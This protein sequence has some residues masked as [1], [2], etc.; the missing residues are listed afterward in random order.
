[1]NYR[2]HFQTKVTPQSQPIPGRKM[3]ANNAGG[4]V[5][6]PNDWSLLDRFLIL[7]T[8]GGS[9]YVGEKELTIQNAQIAQK[10][11]SLDGSRVVKRLVEISEAGRAPKNDQ[12]LFVLAMAAGLGNKETKKLALESLSKVARTGTHLF[13]FLE[14]VEGFRGWGRGLR[15]AVGKWYTEKN[16]D[17]LAYQLIKYQQRGGWSHRDALRLAHPKNEN[18]DALFKWVVSGELQV[19]KVPTLISAKT[20]ADKATTEKE[21]VNLINDTKL[22]WEAIPTQWLGSKEVWK[23]LL[24][25]LPLTALIRNL[26]RMTANET[27][28]PLSESLE[29]VREKLGNQEWLKKARV[30][31]MSLLVALKTYEQGH[32]EKGKLSWQPLHQIVDALDNAFYLSFGNVEPTNKRILFAI[33]ASGSMDS[34]V[35]GAT[36]ITCRQASV[37]LTLVN[38]AIEPNYHCVAF[39]EG[40]HIVDLPISKKQR[41]TDAMRL[42]ERTIRPQGTDCSLPILY[43]LQKN[44]KVDAFVILTDS[45]SWAGQVHVVQAL[46]QYRNKINPQARLIVQAMVANHCS[47]ADENDMLSLNVAGFDT[48]TPQL[49]SDFI[50]GQF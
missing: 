11:I 27:L 35:N 50:S 23:A 31:P 20:A 5:F 46:E 10:L 37:A 49:I 45:E 47:I 13:Q 12:A 22:P 18:F 2:K 1:M 19:D 30:H 8:Q 40:N 25:N 14:Y 32:G 21:I 33:D 42:L 29:I 9:Y 39:T 4:Y 26:G 17:S 16:L 48:S 36:N 15:E 3:V 41:L 38:A 24:P 43:V 44:L 28:V 7:G 6:Q 34:A